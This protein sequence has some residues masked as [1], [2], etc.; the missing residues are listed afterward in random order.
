V[1]R[2]TG[3]ICL[4]LLAI[5][6][7]LGSLWVVDY[8]P[9]HDGPQHVF[10]AHLESK[11][12]QMPPPYR[13]LVIAHRH[14][15]SHAF[16]RIFIPL[17]RLLGWRRALQVTLSFWVMIWTS[18]A[19][20]LMLAV[21]PRRWLSATLIVLLAPP[22]GLYMGFFNYVAAT[23]VGFW[24]LA[25]AYRRPR[26]G[27]TSAVALS[28]TL[29]V[30]AM[31]H[32]FSC[33]LTGFTLLLLVLVRSPRPDRM[34][35]LLQL[36]AIGLPAFLYSLAVVVISLQRPGPTL[37][38]GPVEQLEMVV[39]SA[40][41]GPWW[42]CLPVSLLATVGVVMA[43]LGRRQR[44]AGERGLAVAA[45]AL[46]VMA[47]TMPFEMPGWEGLAPRFA[48][49]A[50]VCG[51]ALLPVEQLSRRQRGAWILLLVILIIPGLSWTY[52]FHSRLADGCRPLIKTLEADI[53]RTGFR[54]FASFRSCLSENVS[55]ETSSV[56]GACFVQHFG[57]LLSIEQGGLPPTFQGSPA[58]HRFSFLTTQEAGMPRTENL[59]WRALVASLEALPQGPEHA[60]S[61]A[62]QWFAVSTRIAEHASR[63]EDLSIF[64]SR[65]E[66]S[67]IVKRGFS[68]DL[69]TDEV[70]IGRFRGCPC[71]VV[72]PEDW[73]GR[74]P[75]IVE[76]G[77]WPLRQPSWSSILK[78]P[79]LNRRLEL[80]NAPCG[81]IWIRLVLDLDGSG[82]MSDGDLLCKSADR[83]GQVVLTGRTNESTWNLYSE[84]AHR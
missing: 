12:D 51:L 34:R 65:A 83:T 29:V 66:R 73:L 68:S 31:L 42:R 35:R 27:L 70:F 64:G 49:T 5:A 38:F 60:A 37:W 59:D 15:T 54:F 75:V 81:P 26:P 23:G 74:A 19:V 11:V 55:N 3:P 62:A 25:A 61:N 10:S 18:G 47:A 50:I 14:L 46:L 7:V 82:T 16:P 22:W 79:R 52:R 1:G 58:L 39:R 57:S 2:R 63:F 6:V 20:A 13:S 17:E 48:P 67:G 33:A 71:E 45:A 53:S 41:V 9:T 77:W 28:G 44:S 76:Y 80:P 56:K 69:D 72:L 8:L 40:A 84:A 36:A 30:Q 21:E 24:I 32:T 4:L 43:L 78:I